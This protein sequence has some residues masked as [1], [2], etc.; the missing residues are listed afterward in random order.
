MIGQFHLR[1]I[2]AIMI[3]LVVGND[4]PRIT[5]RVY[6]IC[7]LFF[8]RVLHRVDEHV[9][10]LCNRDVPKSKAMLATRVGIFLPTVHR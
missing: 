7:M 2:L 1:I 5:K 8:P 4:E 6:L 10:G 3:S 9:Y